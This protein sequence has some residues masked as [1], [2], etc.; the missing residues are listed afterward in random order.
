MEVWSCVAPVVGVGFGVS[1]SVQLL[2]AVGCNGF[3]KT[4]RLDSSSQ[5]RAIAQDA[6]VSGAR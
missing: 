4:L 3:F 2:R 1:G 6:R 5:E